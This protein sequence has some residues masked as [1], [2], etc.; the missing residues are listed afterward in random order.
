MNIWTK[1]LVVLMLLGDLTLLAW[2][3]FEPDVRSELGGDTGVAVRVG[4]IFGIFSYVLSRES[5]QT[6]QMFSVVSS[7]AVAAV[8]SGLAWWYFDYA[9][10]LPR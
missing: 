7:L 6:S 5:K 4:T 10:W 1:L 3:F 8:F 9:K 2:G